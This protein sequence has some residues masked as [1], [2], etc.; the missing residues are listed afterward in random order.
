VRVFLDTN[1][2]VSAFA[3]RGL[4]A[5]LLRHVLTEHELVVGEVVLTELRRVLAEWIRLPST[6]IAEIEAFLR[7]SIVV[8][9]PRR[10]SEVKLRDPS[11]AWVL[12]SA[13][14]GRADVLVSGDDDLLELRARLPVSIMSPRQFW[15]MARG[16]CR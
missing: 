13:I 12:A 9:R 4:C 8:P 6:T 1:V 5:D 7:E 10:P 14:T 11:D 2:L 15:D 16:R 3:T